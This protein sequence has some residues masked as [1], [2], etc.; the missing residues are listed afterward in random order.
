[1]RQS[2][3]DPNLIPLRRDVLHPNI[4]VEQDEIHTDVSSHPTES[5]TNTL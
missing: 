2:V 3:T 1:V 5:I 4:T